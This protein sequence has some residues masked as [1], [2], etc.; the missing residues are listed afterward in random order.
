[1]KKLP[2]VF[3]L[4][5]LA[6]APVRV[7][8]MTEADKK[9]EHKKS[10]DSKGTL[11]KNT[12]E[13]WLKAHEK[14]IGEVNSPPVN[15]N[16]ETEI[17]VFVEKGEIIE[18][19]TLKP[20]SNADAQPNS[21]LVNADEESEKEDLFN[22][23][24]LEQRLQE[25]REVVADLRGKGTAL[26]EQE[27]SGLYQ[28]WTNRYE[29]YE[30]K[31]D[32]FERTNNIGTIA[33][34]QIEERLKKLLKT[35]AEAMQA[36]KQSLENITQGCATRT[37]D[38]GHFHFKKEEPNLEALVSSYDYSTT[39]NHSVFWTGWHPN[40]SQCN[41]ERAKEYATRTNKKV[42]EITPGGERLGAQGFHNPESYLNK[43]DADF[44]WGVA[45]RRFVEGASGHVVAF[46]LEKVD[47]F[48]T[49]RKM[50]K[51]V[52]KSK[53][54]AFLSEVIVKRD[55]KLLLTEAEQELFEREQAVEKKLHPLFQNV[56]TAWE[57]IGNYSAFHP[58]N[59]RD[60]LGSIDV[61]NQSTSVQQ[62]LSQ[63]ASQLNPF[64]K[65]VKA[66]S[67]AW[68]ELRKAIYS[69][70]HEGLE[71]AHIQQVSKVR[72]K[73]RELEQLETVSKTWSEEYDRFREAMQFFDY[74]IFKAYQERG[75]MDKAARWKEETRI[76][77][78]KQQQQMLQQS[79]AQFIRGK[80]I[81]GLSHFDDSQDS[82]KECF[83]QEVSID[84]MPP[85]F[86]QEKQSGTVIP[87]TPPYLKSFNRLKFIN[88]MFALIRLLGDLQQY[89]KPI[90]EKEGLAKSFF[91]TSPLLDNY[92]TFF[93]RP[94]YKETINFL[95]E[96]LEEVQESK[97]EESLNSITK[98]NAIL[99]SYST[100][101]ELKNL[102]AWI[103][104]EHGKYRQE[105][106]CLKEHAES[107]R[108]D[109]KTD[110]SDFDCWIYKKKKE[111]LS[112]LENEKEL[113]PSLSS[114]IDAVILE[115]EKTTKI[116][117]DDYHYTIKKLTPEAR[118]EAAIAE[119]ENR[120]E[121]ADAAME[122]SEG[123]SFSKKATKE[124]PYA[125]YQ[126]FY[127]L[128]DI[129]DKKTKQ[130]AEA[131][132]ETIRAYKDTIDVY[133]T[134][135]KENG[136][137]VSPAIPYAECFESTQCLNEENLLLIGNGGKRTLSN[138]RLEDIV[139]KDSDKAKE[140][141]KEVINKS[142]FWEY[143]VWG[144]PSLNEAR[145]NVQA[146]EKQIERRENISRK[147]TEQATE[148]QKTQN[149]LAQKK[150]AETELAKEKEK[151]TKQA[152]EERQK[153]LK[154]NQK[155][156]EKFSKK[157]EKDLKDLSCELS[158]QESLEQHNKHIKSRIVNLSKEIKEKKDE[159]KE[160]REKNNITTDTPLLD[161]YNGIK[162]LF[163]C[164]SHI[165]SN[166]VKCAPP[167]EDL[168]N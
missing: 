16:T 60:F 65:K 11:P 66:L 39:E 146:A 74:Q 137:E 92:R 45:S 57:K 151:V 50:E 128:L 153:T 82:K 129:F 142:S 130:H 72:E 124:D 145:E 147:I 120:I 139:K 62:E 83:Q 13:K 27:L 122:Q 110:Y 69:F 95:V 20:T 112:R 1:M 73:F 158:N 126:K 2:L 164:P 118:H 96:K 140:K 6:L 144:S 117:N 68:D 85:L 156:I 10:G 138:N 55:Q 94:T 31:S 4:G 41:F 97:I 9:E 132:K 75:E 81:T 3:L 154:E 103:K 113:L 166:E 47:P 78:E 91:I 22:L 53:E 36:L 56:R 29:R 19:N 149:T 33:G 77:E 17:E 127:N 89:I 76:Y 43:R 46:V 90:E 38:V 71:N 88:P 116:A 93:G 107:I 52:L 161:L 150:E 58:D 125:P 24:V 136:E 32:I 26:S 18:D 51:P 160:I 109:E 70:Q 84:D 133:K 111:E 98:D 64:T 143:R 102:L 165:T 115:I 168:N 8:A 159:I 121:Q 48:T 135:P 49:Y 152:E 87:E 162:S 42:L 157:H 155:E 30:K 101:A 54:T 148:I 61:K 167:P 105:K 108:D 5:T 86:S 114:R 119:G 21:S 40:S 44:I 37:D 131:T 79:A 163:S 34:Q 123:S 80:I 106:Q 28:K 25:A 59:I 99:Q 141:E 67:E 104:E 100:T 23:D 134:P 7:S 15:N 63:F 14:A 12:D 35:S